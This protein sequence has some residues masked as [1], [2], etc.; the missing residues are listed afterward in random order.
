M[1]A[2]AWAAAVNANPMADVQSRI[3]TISQRMAALIPAAAPGQVN[4]GVATYEMPAGASS[5]ADVLATAQSPSAP[6]GVT[7][8]AGAVLPVAPPSTQ[9]TGDSVVAAASKYLGIP[10]AW[11]G[12]D[13]GTGLDCS[14]LVQ[15][16]Y[17]DVGVSLPR[18]SRDQAKVGNPVASLADA[19]P[20][21][22]LFFEHG[23]VD[24]IGIYV[25]DG[26]MLNAPHTGSVVRV[27]NL[28]QAPTSI[29]RVLPGVTTSYAASDP[30]AA[31]QPAPLTTAALNGIFTAA[32]RRSGVPANLLAAVATVES[33]DDPHA[34]SRSGAEGLMQLMPGTAA[35][36]G[37]DAMDPVQAVDGA[38]RLLA[39]GLKEFGSVDL[40]LAAYNAGG[41][42]V[43]RFG[44]MPPYAETTSYVRKV[45]NAMKEVAL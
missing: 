26:R 2:H 43:R 23:A 31:S 6:D 1:V 17:A 8:A 24:H 20:G 41:G 44:G 27:E 19:K 22:L 7:D 14:G 32:S 28:D 38:A 45:R 15:R 5:F 13:P 37:V 4:G 3:A 18:V 12:T 40:A 29:R 36:L 11:G 34:V 16:A 39:S 25:G 21:D 10:Y 9:A 42:A 35:S 30:A 33:G